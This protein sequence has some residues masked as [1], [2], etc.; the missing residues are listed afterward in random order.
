[1]LEQFFC[2]QLLIRGLAMFGLTIILLNITPGHCEEK[3]SHLEAIHLRSSKG[4]NNPLPTPAAPTA[5]LGHAQ[6]IETNSQ[7]AANRTSSCTVPLFFKANF[8]FD[9]VSF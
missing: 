2:Q 6:G 8:S 5:A 9:S 3:R 4:S 7:T 1:M